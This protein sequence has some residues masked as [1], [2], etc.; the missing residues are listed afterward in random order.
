MHWLNKLKKF[1]YTFRVPNI[2]SPMCDCRRGEKTAEHFVMLCPKET[3]RRYLL[4]DEQGQQQLWSTLTV[5]PLHAKRLAR[6]L[7]ESDLRKQFS[8]AKKL[9]YGVH[10]QD[11]NRAEELGTGE[12]QRSERT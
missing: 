4:H 6:W 11:N 8:L 5:K 12:G 10:S 2:D 3:Y 1:L 7:I 9:V